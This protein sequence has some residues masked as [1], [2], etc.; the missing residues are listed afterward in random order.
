MTDPNPVGPSGPG[1]S[2]QEAAQRLLRHGPNA[3]TDR[4]HQGLWSTLRGIA[5]EP[6]FLLLL[7]AAGVYLVLG[8][9]GEGLLLAFFALVTVGL[10]IAQERRSQHALDALRDLAAPQVRA[11]R[12]GR[13]V[14]I[15]A[16]DLVPG[17][18]FLV[19]E[20]E[21]VAADGLL[22]SGTG[23]SADESLLTG[24]SVPVHKLASNTL[25]QLPEQAGGDGSAAVFAGT[26]VVSGHGQ[27]EVLATGRHTQVGRI[28]ASLARIDSAPTPLQQQLGQLV[29]L[30]G[31]V[32]GLASAMLLLVYGLTRGD[33]MQGLLSAVA[34]GMA[35]LPEEFPMVLTVFLALGAWRLAR[36][37][38]LARRPAAIEA[39][40]S[41]TVLCVDKTGTLTENRMQLRRLATA[42]DDVRLEPGQTLPEAVHPLLEFGLLASRR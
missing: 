19:A 23:V 6:M 5:T 17:D 13:I 8:D 39:L 26:L 21:R 32:A 22:R 36:E 28:G 29:R 12:D 9:L 41:A 33:W 16:R 7:L 20:G 34:L 18:F 31:L 24:E 10:V 30:F 14:R 15:P 2:Q 38:V 4:E 3:L 11:L 35:M 27:A 1:L 42:T 25:Q 37:Q 40:G